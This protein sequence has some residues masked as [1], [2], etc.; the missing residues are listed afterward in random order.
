MAY[1]Y[2]DK[3]YEFAMNGQ[4]GKL[5]GTPPLSKGKL[6][7]ASLALGAAVTVVCGIIGGIIL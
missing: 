5:A 7:L 6:A 3:V 1:K 2:K 4:T